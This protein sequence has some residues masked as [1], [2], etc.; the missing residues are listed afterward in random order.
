L[1]GD[2]NGDGRADIVAF[3]KNNVY[4]SLSTGHAFSAPTTSL[5]TFCASAAA[6]R[7]TILIPAPWA[8]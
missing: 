3:G 4:I 7:A 2:V 1:L 6:G 8:M 5:A